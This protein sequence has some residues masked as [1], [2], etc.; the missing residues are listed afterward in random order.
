MNVILSK[1]T[2][3]IDAHFNSTEFQIQNRRLLFSTEIANLGSQPTSRHTLSTIRTDISNSNC[4]WVCSVLRRLAVYIRSSFFIFL[5]SSLN[6]FWLARI[7]ASKV[8]ECFALFYRTSS[9]SVLW[10]F[11][12]SFTTFLWVASNYA[13]DISICHLLRLD[14]FGT[15]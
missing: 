1:W 8:E 12:L 6:L 10:V 13:F 4:Y 11:I 3:N 7:F 5:F 15:S 9:L 14:L 2:I